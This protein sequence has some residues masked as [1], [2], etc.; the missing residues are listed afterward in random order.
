MR[1]IGFLLISIV[2]LGL[3]LIDG[4]LHWWEGLIMLLLYAFYVLLVIAMGYPYT[5]K[6]GSSN[7]ADRPPSPAASFHSDSALLSPKTEEHLTLVD[8]Y[9][10]RSSSC[11]F[12]DAFHSTDQ[13]IRHRISTAEMYR[14]RCSSM[15]AAVQLWD[16][17][18][19]AQNRPPSQSLLRHHQNHLACPTCKRAAMTTTQAK[20]KLLASYGGRTLAARSYSFLLT[21]VNHLFPIFSTWHMQG[22]MGRIVGILNIPAVV[23]LG[24]TV[25]VVAPSE[26]DDEVDEILAQRSNESSLPPDSNRTQGCRCGRDH[27]EENAH[28]D[29]EQ[30]ADEKSPLM[31]GDPNRYLNAA[32]FCSTIDWHHRWIIIMQSLLAPSFIL[33]A[34]GYHDV[35]LSDNIWFPGYLLGVI[36]GVILACPV[37]LFVR[38][39]RHLHRV[40]CFVDDHRDHRA[41][42]V[43]WRSP[44]LSFI[45]FLIGVLWIFFIANE[46]VG[47]LKAAGKILKI[48]DPILGVTILAFGNSIG[49]LVSNV[50]IARMGFP[51]MSIS[52][53]FAGPLINL[54]LT[55]GVS[56][57]I[58]IGKPPAPIKRSLNVEFTYVGLLLLMLVCF[59]GISAQKFRIHRYFGAALLVMYVVVIGVT[60]TLDLVVPDLRP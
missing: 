41:I 9:A 56:G 51:T 46:V 11:S 31:G 1:D 35:S 43:P 25:P 22:F 29:W 21:V 42:T 45:G 40:A 58:G 18:R 32:D 57:M 14:Q 4:K 52:A 5:R 27:D 55:L 30:D 59:F 10:T 17:W 12:D 60:I 44:L 20:E 49:D 2:I 39:Y 15:N 3:I 28:V 26:E 36:L 24:L 33:F 50:T 19:D 6:N 34:L 53:S 16:A 23:C 8:G 7:S 54:L 37:A 38:P 48:S 13:V 47:L